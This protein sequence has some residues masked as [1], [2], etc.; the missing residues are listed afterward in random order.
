MQ[1]LSNAIYHTHGHKPKRDLTRNGVHIGWWP[2]RD[3][4]DQDSKL[5]I[6]GAHKLSTKGHVEPDSHDKMRVKLATD[7]FDPSTTAAIRTM[8]DV[9]PEHA[10]AKAA[11]LEYLEACWE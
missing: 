5:G 4:F 6:S 10:A 1:K 11:T 8:L 9:T 7:V 2:V 3:M